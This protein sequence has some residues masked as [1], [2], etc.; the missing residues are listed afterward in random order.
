MSDN[1]NFDVAMKFILKWEGGY[2]ND[3]DDPGGETKYG[4]SKRAYPN[5]DIKNLTIEDAKA[6][7]KRDYWDKAGL[8]RYPQDKAVVLMNVAV[9][10]GVGKA[11]AFASEPDFQTVIQRIREYYASLIQKNPKLEK[12]RKGWMNRTNDLQT[13]LTS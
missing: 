9:N 3:K 1:H 8:D 4:I 2:V 7:Y 13:Y 6:L 12:Y 11:V 10:M 5:V